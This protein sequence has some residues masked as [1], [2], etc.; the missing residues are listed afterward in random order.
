MS[1]LKLLPVAIRLPF[2]WV[3]VMAARA[4]LT[5]V[6]RWNEHNQYPSNCSFVVNKQPELIKRPVIC[7]ASLSLAPWLLVE[8][9]PNSGQVFKSQSGLRLF[10]FLHQLFADVM[11][12][13]KSESDVLCQRAFSE[14]FSNQ[15]CVCVERLP[16]FD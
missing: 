6:S 15:A 8:T 4:S 16:L 9:I 14:V 11:V 1:T 5:R 2:F 13:P 7:P 3:D 12:K 10:R